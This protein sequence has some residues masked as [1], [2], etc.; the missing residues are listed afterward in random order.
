M[1]ARTNHFQLPAARGPSP[2]PDRV[3]MA[4]EVG[5][6]VAVRVG[7]GAVVLYQ[8][9]HV[10]GHEVDVRGASRPLIVIRRCVAEV[11]K[12]IRRHRIVVE[13]VVE[14]AAGASIMI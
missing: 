8:T 1:S 4:G 9:S 5:R 12:R 13:I 14:S 6:A 2:A 3:Q 10:D 11:A 7:T